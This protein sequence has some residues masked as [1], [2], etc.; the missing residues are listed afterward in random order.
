[1]NSNELNDSSPLAGALEQNIQDIDI[2]P[3]PI[4]IDRIRSA[5]NEDMPNFKYVGQLVS[6]DVS[7][8]AGLIKTANSP[9]FGYQSR[10]RSVNEA[11]LMLGL[12]V[13]CRA[14]ATISL[15]QAFP[16]SAH[17][18]RFWDASARIAALSGWLARQIRRPKLRPDDVENDILGVNAGT[19]LAG[20]IDAPDLEPAQ[21]HGLGGKHIANLGRADAKR[22]RPKRPVCARM[23][24]ATSNGGAGL[25]DALLGAD[26]VHNALP[27][28]GTI[29]ESDAKVRTVFAQFI[30]HGLRQWIAVRLHHLVGRHDMIHRRKGAVWH[31]HLE[32]QVAQ[33]A[34]RLRARDLMDEVRADE[35]LRLAIGQGADAVG[36]PD[37]FEE[38][39]GHGRMEARG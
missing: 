7:L 11:L 32:F 20:D 29:K 4:I 25:R 17:Y 37:F 23:G 3:R 13:T 28:G 16:N 21:R 35:Q 2:P 24:I 12:D 15:R 34:E 26:D 1:M 36:V 33:H 18:E 31:R 5:M 14:I 6:A 27:A 9:Y 22:N 30:H 8:A 19:Q 38:G 39:F 10:A